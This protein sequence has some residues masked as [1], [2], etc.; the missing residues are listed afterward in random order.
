MT[1][2]G[3]ELFKSELDRVLDLLPDEPLVHGYN[4]SKNH[5]TNSLIDVTRSQTAHPYIGEIK[6]LSRGA[7]NG[8]RNQCPLKIQRTLKE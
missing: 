7:N 1:N 3:L 2:C 6:S 8:P 4:S 5:A